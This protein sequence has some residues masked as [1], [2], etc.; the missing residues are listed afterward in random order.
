MAPKALG[1]DLCIKRISK[2]LFDIAR[3]RCSMA[4]RDSES[5]QACVVS[6]SAF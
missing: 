2:G 4:G 1:H 3:S 6:E 5:D